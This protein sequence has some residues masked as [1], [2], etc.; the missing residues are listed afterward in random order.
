MYT[1]GY[2]VR[3]LNKWT[4]V[5]V[6]QMVHVA[7]HDYTTQQFFSSGIRIQFVRNVGHEL[8]KQKINITILQ[9]QE[10]KYH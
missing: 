6:Q 9:K 1:T 2:E 8:S 3:Q 5:F 7:A 4:D 10:K